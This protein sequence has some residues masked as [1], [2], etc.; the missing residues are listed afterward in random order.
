MKKH[1][2]AIK[3]QVASEESA[4][5]V[6]ENI[7]K[8]ILNSNGDI[9]VS[10]IDVF[11]NSKTLS[12]VYVEN[13]EL[14]DKVTFILTI[15]PKQQFDKRIFA[16]FHNVVIEKISKYLKDKDN[17]VHVIDC[18]L[19][20]ND[21]PAEGKKQKTRIGEMVQS[22]LEMMQLIKHP[23]WFSTASDKANFKFGHYFTQ[24]DIINI[25]PEKIEGYPDCIMY[26]GN[27]NLD[28]I[29][30]DVENLLDN[31]MPDL[32]MNGDYDFDFFSVKQ[33]ID[34]FAAKCPGYFIGQFPTIPYEVGAFYR[35][36]EFDR[37]NQKYDMSKYKDNLQKY[38]KAAY[39][40]G[41][42][43]PNQIVDAMKYM[44]SVIHYENSDMSKEK[45]SDVSNL[46]N[47][48]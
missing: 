6:I 37:D 20:L 10:K 4:K 41:I 21:I 47:I 24:M 17:V 14:S 34:K 33:L 40:L 16:K 29:I 13:A 32:T 30:V 28:W 35:E 5:H 43:H 1:I 45:N 46:V 38:Q 12:K 22:V 9:E 27:S 19:H 25:G 23:V 15:G 36:A 42:R 8:P 3:D 26:S 31:G 2:F 44:R 7:V 18:G 11:V 39:D 48:I